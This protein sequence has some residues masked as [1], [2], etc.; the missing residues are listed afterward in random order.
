MV[1]YHIATVADWDR[2]DGDYRPTGWES[3]G[4]V[5]FS[6]PDQLVAT[7]NRRFAG[8]RDL[9]LLTVEPSRLG[10]P[11]V[12]EDSYGSGTEFPHV[13]GSI[14]LDAVVAVSEFLPG[15]DGRFDWW[16]PQPPA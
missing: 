14:E 9:V 16:K 15:P 7:A 6:G 11:L 12:W 10:S 2:R 8:R 4:F 1:V 5:H 13:Y 3:E